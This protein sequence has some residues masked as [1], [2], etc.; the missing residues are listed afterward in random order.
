MTIA[1]NDHIL[2]ANVLNRET[3]RVKFNGTKVINSEM[4]N[5]NQIL[6]NVGNDQNIGKKEFMS[7]SEKCGMTNM[8]YRKSRSIAYG[9]TGGRRW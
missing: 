8:R 4:T 2:G 5:R 9:D 3:K 6:D 7:G 1:A